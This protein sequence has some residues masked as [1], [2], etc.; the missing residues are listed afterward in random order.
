MRCPGQ[1]S[2]RA[3]C[4]GELGEAAVWWTWKLPIARV[5]EISHIFGLNE[6]GQENNFILLLGCVWR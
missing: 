6:H 4:A 5:P 3:P 1:I 2:Y